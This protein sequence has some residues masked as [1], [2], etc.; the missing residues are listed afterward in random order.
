M[1]TA[2]RGDAGVVSRSKTPSPASRDCMPRSP[3]NR[4]KCSIISISQGDETESTDDI[5]EQ[6]RSKR[7]PVIPARMASV[8]AQQISRRQIEPQCLPARAPVARPLEM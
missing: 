3:Q 5:D 8:D 6:H 4:K 7:E 1:S 2:A